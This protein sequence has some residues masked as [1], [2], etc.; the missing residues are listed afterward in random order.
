MSAGGGFGFRPFCF[1]TLRAFGHPMDMVRSAKVLA[2]VLL[3]VV[4]P[5]IICVPLLTAGNAPRA[6]HMN[7]RPSHPNHACCTVNR[8][9]SFL[10]SVISHTR[11]VLYTAIAVAPGY[12]AFPTRV[13]VEIAQEFTDTSPLLIAPLRI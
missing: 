13:G 3:A 12:F 4:V 11:D 9:S 8:P 1:A 5:F 10:P 2:A 6:C 7:H